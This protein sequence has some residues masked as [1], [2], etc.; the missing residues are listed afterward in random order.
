M[1][2][3]TILDATESLRSWAYTDSRI[4]IPAADISEALQLDYEKAGRYPTE[5]ECEEFVCG[6]EDGEVPEELKALFPATD[7]LLASYW[8]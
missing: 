8:E 7:A 5:K 6:N 1:R 3:A 4:D 2:R